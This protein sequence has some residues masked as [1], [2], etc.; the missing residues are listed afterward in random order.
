VDEWEAGFG[1]KS[2]LKALLD[3][4][5][6]I[7]DPRPSHKV[8]YP[9]SEVLLLAVCGTIADCDSFEAIGLWGDRHLDFLRRFLPYHHR[10]PTGRWLTLLITRSIRR[11][12][13]PALR[14]GCAPAGRIGPSLE[15][16]S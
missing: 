15:G 14:T 13:Q 7:E 5:S 9:L 8:A 2:R 16:Q 6:E 10:L 1:E 4:F 12:F 3:H 11:C